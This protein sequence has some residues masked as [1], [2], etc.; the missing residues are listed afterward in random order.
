MPQRI[1]HLD[2]KGAP[3]TLAYAESLLPLLRRW[4]ATGLLLEWE[5]VSAALAAVAERVPVW[6][7]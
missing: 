2:F 4:G 6:L 3:P 7:Y 1:V 5:D